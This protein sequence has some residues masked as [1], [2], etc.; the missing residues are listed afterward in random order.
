MKKYLSFSLSTLLSFSLV[1][2][3]YACGGGGGTT[4]AGPGVTVDE[5][6]GVSVDE[7]G[8]TSDTYTVVLNTNP[9]GDVTIT[10]T[11]DA[12]TDLGVGAGA[13]ITLTFTSASGTTPQTV[14]VTAVDDALVEANPHTSTISH[15]ITASADPAYPTSLAIASVTANITDNDTAGVAINES[16]G[17]TDVTEGGQTDTYTVVLDSEPTA[18]VTVTV[19]PDAETDVGAGAGTDITLTFIPGSGTTPQTVTVTAVDDGVHET[20]PHTSTINNTSSSTDPDFDGQTIIVTA[21]I[22]DNDRFLYTANAAP[23]PGGIGTVSGFTIDPSTGSLTSVGAATNLG[24]DSEPRSVAVNPA[25]TFLYVAERGSDQVS[26]FT[27]DSTTGVLSAI[28]GSP[29]STGVGIEPRSLVVHP[30]GS[31]LY[32]ANQ[33]SD[34]V[35]AFTINTDGSLTPTS[36]AT[37]STGANTGPR[38]VAVEPVNGSFLY[39][40]LDA[41]SQ[42]MGFSIN[43]DGTLFALSSVST[44]SSPREVTVDPFGA[45]AYVG[46]IGNDLVSGYSIDPTT[47]DLSELTTEGSPFPTTGGNSDPRKVV[48]TPDGMFAYVTL[49]SAGSADIFAYSVGADGSLAALSPSTYD[50]TAILPVHA[51]VDPSGK[52]LYAPNANSDNIS[53]YSIDSAT[54]ALTKI[55]GPD[56]NGNFNTG[57]E[58]VSTAIT[59]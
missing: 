10:I 47:G 46:C 53:A 42:V 28:S 9:S 37:F 12:Q 29:F 58:P 33:G 23:F 32:V 5:Q 20:S 15:S 44:G 40:A 31:Y 57:D 35:S 21:N 17:S 3:F 27:I 18:N 2:A 7:T 43:P 1:I 24:A 38:S 4:A 59:P 54:G 22:T 34:D 56:A 16:S 52:Y 26:A 48:V 39:V 8:P 50:N 36:P 6:G 55:T 11:P 25:G 41:T 51:A 13:A 19:S 14:T 30:N 45:F 49:G